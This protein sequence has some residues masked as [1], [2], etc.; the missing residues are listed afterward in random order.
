M[1]QRRVG[2]DGGINHAD[3]KL[4]GLGRRCGGPGFGGAIIFPGKAI[5]MVIIIDGFTVVSAQGS[6]RFACRL[7]FRR[8]QPG[9]LAAKRAQLA[10]FDKGEA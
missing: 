3:P 5:I 8:T 1:A 10:V 7:P 2:S 4:A 6:E 9:D